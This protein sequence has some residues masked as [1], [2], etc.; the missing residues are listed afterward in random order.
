M[1]VSR[2]HERP[3]DFVKIAKVV[4]KICVLHIGVTVRKKLS[5]PRLSGLHG[6]HG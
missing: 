1:P 6:L 5:N 4:E 3:I 2:T